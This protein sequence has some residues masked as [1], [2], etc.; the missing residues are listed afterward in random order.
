V[1]SKLT[2]TLVQL[3]EKGAGGIVRAESGKIKKQLVLRAGHIAF[4]ESNLQDEHLVRMM[5]K[6][7]LLPRAAMQPVTDQMKSGKSADEAIIA[8][9][10]IDPLV[11]TMAA[12]EQALVILASLMGNEDL[13]V[14]Y[15]ACE[16]QIRRSLDLGISIP[17]F[18][19]AAARRA[20]ATQHAPSAIEGTVFPVEGS[21]LALQVVP[22]NPVEAY[23]CSLAEHP[24]AVTEFLQL[25]PPAD[26]P[27]EEILRRL[28]ILGFLSVQSAAAAAAGEK[29]ARDAAVLAAAQL[30]E[31][32]HEFEVSNHYEVLGVAPD[33]QEADIKSAYHQLAK[34]YH[35]DLF[36]SDRYSPALR[37]SAER[38]FTFITAAYTTLINP[39]SRAVYDEQ[40]LTK[41]S[42]VEAAIQARAGVDLDSDKRARALFRVGQD[43]LL[44]MDYDK[45]VMTL[46]ECVFLRPDVARYRLS[47]GIAQT[48]LP[49]YRKEAEQNL[50]RSIELDPMNLESKLALGTL[51]V[52]VNLPRR[53]EAQYSEVLR[54]DPGNG[55]A[56]RRLG[57]LK[58]SVKI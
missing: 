43:A 38:V 44:V 54:L 30:E 21:R 47:L 25:L 10:D 1:S 19:P 46:S 48:E 9:S 52:K 53:A 58:V 37:Q 57:E 18:L 6:A 49:K 16:E 2:R 45:A 51:Y 27:A 12:R 35:P 11:V 22:L 13:A 31:L 39:G 15:F 3:H 40:R 28:L 24:V 29:S 8:A 23:A 32:E 36:Q 34:Q 41:G 17:D 4:A 7:N 56:R 33:A 20:A 50:L 55:E 42:Q 5:I 26:A 14:R